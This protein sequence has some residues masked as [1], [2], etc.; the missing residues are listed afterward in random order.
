M[1]QTDITKFHVDQLIRHTDESGWSELLQVTAIWLEHDRIWAKTIA[2]R[3]L[4]AIQRC[5]YSFNPKYSDI[6]TL[7]EFF[8][9]WKPS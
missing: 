3:G 8:S 2:D 7:D 4:P 6:H 5:N 9:G 1:R